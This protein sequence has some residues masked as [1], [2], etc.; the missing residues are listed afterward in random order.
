MNFGERLDHALERSKKSR[1]E[2][3]E[4]IGVSPQAVGMIIT[5]AGGKERRLSTENHLKA[6]NFLS[7]SPYWLSTG[8]GGIDEHK[9]E[10]EFVKY[11]REMHELKR[12]RLEPLVKEA[13]SKSDLWNSVMILRE[14]ST[15][16]REKCLDFF[17]KSVNCESEKDSEEWLKAFS[18]VV[19]FAGLGR[20]VKNE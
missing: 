18:M 8:E 6:A 12:K 17:I 15:D 11:D 1:R 16:Q 20:N 5:S 14:L 13:R 2:L 9:Q 4:H 7:V 10:D 19:S 3:A